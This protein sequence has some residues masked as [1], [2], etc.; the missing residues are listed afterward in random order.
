MRAELMPEIPVLSK[1]LTKAN[2]WTKWIVVL[3]TLIGMGIAA[4][5]RFLKLENKVPSLEYRMSELE[6]RHV[7]LKAVVDARGDWIKG[8]DNKLSEMIGMLKT[9]ML[10]DK[11]GK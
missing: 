6:R 3:M 1:V 11:D 9:H 5:D 4:R 2:G 8:I 10:Q 7:E